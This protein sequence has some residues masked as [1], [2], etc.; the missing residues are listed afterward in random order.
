[1]TYN[2]GNGLAVP[3]RVAEAVRRS[4]ADIVGLQELTAEQEAGLRDALADDYPYQILHGVGIPGKGLL[5]RYPILEG[6][7]IRGHP[8]RPDLR[9]TVDVHGRTLQVAVVHPEPPRFVAG[10]LRPSVYTN[11][12]ID[13]LIGLLAHQL[14]LVLLGD[15]NMTRLQAQ[16]RR[17]AA[18]GLVDAF[19]VAGRGL[20]RTFPLR[21]GRIPLLP[22]LRL[23]YIW[24]SPALEAVAARVGPDAGSDHL[25][26]LADIRW[27]PC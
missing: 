1:M 5:S 7:Q 6:E 12:Q 27:L 17:V 15:F 2:V 14:P 26:V 8:E 23:D 9:A 11:G 22:V 13:E 3:G 4:D 24:L 20:G 21:R 18:A 10:G 25:P 19:H 16:Y